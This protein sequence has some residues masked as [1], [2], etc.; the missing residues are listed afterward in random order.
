MA[1]PPAR[2]H[3]ARSPRSPRTKPADKT[4]AARGTARAATSIVGPIAPVALRT[5]RRPA[6]GVQ[7]AGT[8]PS[9]IQ[10]SAFQA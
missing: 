5:V 2:C 3:Q 6:V 10:P 4:A 9:A 1:P 7:T 8:Q